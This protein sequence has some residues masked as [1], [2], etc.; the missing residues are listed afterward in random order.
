MSTTYFSSGVFKSRQSISN[1]VDDFMFN[2]EKYPSIVISIK[3]T[4][5]RCHRL[6]VFFNDSVRFFVLL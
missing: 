4:H 2:C 3:N 5:Y 6:Q 1:L